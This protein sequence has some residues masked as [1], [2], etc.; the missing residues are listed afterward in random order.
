MEKENK[1]RKIELK[2]EDGMLVTISEIGNRKEPTI[3]A[4]RMD[5][6]V[7]RSRVKANFTNFAEL[8]SPIKKPELNIKRISVGFKIVW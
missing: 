3:N 7:A 6:V 2:F 5:I 1:T 4:S 8:I